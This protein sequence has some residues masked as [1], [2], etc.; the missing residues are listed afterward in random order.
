[1]SAAFSY[2][3]NSPQFQYPKFKGDIEPVAP[4]AAR[5][6]AKSTDAWSTPV[7]LAQ[8]YQVGSSLPISTTLAFSPTDDVAYTDDVCKAMSL[9]TIEMLALMKGTTPE[10][11]SSAEVSRCSSF[12]D[13]GSCG[14]ADAEAPR[15]PFKLHIPP[16]ATQQQQQRHQQRHSDV[17]LYDSEDEDGED[18]VELRQSAET[19][20]EERDEEGEEEEPMENIFDIEL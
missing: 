5:S 8:N 11:L 3:R 13:L 19:T 7:D 17:R 15:S 12:V 20:D 9:K 16:V 10:L 4:V 14:I 6:F 2:P 18:E 1:M